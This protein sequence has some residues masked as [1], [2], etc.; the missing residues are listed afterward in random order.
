MNE[1]SG[2]RRPTKSFFGVRPCRRRL[3][4]E[5]A[6]TGACRLE[7]VGKSTSMNILGGSQAE[8]RDMRLDGAIYA[9]ADPK[10]ASAAGI[11][12]IHQRLNLF[13]EPDDRGN[14]FIDRFPGEISALHQ[15]CADPTADGTSTWRRSIFSHRPSTPVSKLSQGE[16]QLVE[17][18]KAL[19]AQCQAHHFRRADHLSDAPG[20]RTP[21]RHH[22][23]AEE[24]LASASFTSVNALEDVMAVCDSIA[25]LRDGH[26]AGTRKQLRSTCS[27]S[28][29]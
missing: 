5:K 9:R 15:P 21:V 7:R 6:S 14:L 29:P 28:S 24:P 16:R 3:L 17:I 1:T 18:A 8:R 10:D 11:A 2:S 4:V 25:V 26:V 20:S 12:F 23:P 27:A 19:S 13:P 22:R